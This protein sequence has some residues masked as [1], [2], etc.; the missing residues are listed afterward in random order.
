MK[1]RT[2]EMKKIARIIADAILERDTVE[3][4][5]AQSHELCKEFPLYP[6]M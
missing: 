5:R 1:W 6:N 2:S 4:L 3:N